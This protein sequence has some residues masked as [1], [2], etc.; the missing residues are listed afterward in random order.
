M[1]KAPSPPHLTLRHNTWFARLTVP[2]DVRDKIGRNIFI[3]STGQRDPE[4]AYAKALPLL[5]SWRARIAAARHGTGDPLQAEV[6]RLTQQ[7]RKAR[8][9]QEADAVLVGE[10]I[11]WVL[12]LKGKA[13]ERALRDADNDVEK[14][15]P[16]FRPVIATITGTSTPFLDRFEDWRKATHLK[17]KSLDQAVSAIRQFADD[18]P[19]TIET[20]TGSDV[21]KW[22]EG[23]TSKKSG[24]PLSANAKQWKL[25][26]LRDYWSF[27]QAHEVVSRTNRPFWDRKL[28][29]HRN[30]VGRAEDA[31]KRFE[32]VDVV[33]LWR[34]A[35][36]QG[37]RYL[38][39][40]IRI[41]AYSGARREGIARLKVHDIRH[42]PGTDI[43]FLHFS[44]KSAAGV[45]DVPI[46]SA[47]R[48]LT[49]ELREASQDGYLLPGGENKYNI[50]GDLLGKR[51]TEL[52]R[53][54]GFD[55]HYTF[56]SIRHTVAHL[57]ENAG[58]PETV[59]ADIVGHTIAT[60][61]YGVYAGKTAMDK[62]L[63]WLERAIRYPMD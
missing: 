39:A 26:G 50:R 21:Q 42:D 12:E 56:H 1:A 35:Q 62:R 18:V 25:V 32:P 7:F 52:K 51:F 33:R 23:L 58:A 40:M 13:G 48:D 30:G 43:D 49:F 55:E 28:K 9:R 61:T 46:H 44:E 15:F 5:E 31:R 27:L 47:T 37:D 38:C 41:A 22:L 8:N 24:E 57:F 59:A 29:D 11:T 19:K 4:R 63:E 16:E 36:G 10:V 60:L 20:L 17:G 2:P 14:A 54:M 6:E 45:R 34:Q 53:S 3:A